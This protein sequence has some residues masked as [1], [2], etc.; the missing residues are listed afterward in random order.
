MASIFFM[1]LW[2]ADNVGVWFSFNLRARN[3]PYATTVP[4]R[5]GRLS[6]LKSSALQCINKMAAHFYLPFTWFFFHSRLQIQQRFGG[7]ASS[8]LRTVF[9]A[10]K[11]AATALTPGW[12][13]PRPQRLDSDCGGQMRAWRLKEAGRIEN[14]RSDR[15]RIGLTVSR[16]FVKTHELPV[17]IG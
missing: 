10:Q 14:G 6:W 16:L 4:S 8:Y 5:Q 12:I 15:I 2:F 17:I 11:A 13:S 1:S 3:R 7:F 9:A